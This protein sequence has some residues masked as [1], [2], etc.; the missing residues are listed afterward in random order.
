A[1]DCVLFANFKTTTAKAKGATK[2]KAWG[3]G[4][5]VMFTERRPAFDA[6]NRFDLP[7]E[8]SLSWEEF[9]DHVAKAVPAAKADELL[10]LFKG[11]EADATA[12]L[13]SIG[14]LLDGQ[15]L[16]DLKAKHRKTI[17]NRSDDFL[18]AVA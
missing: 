16:A 18:Q 4:T 6:K 11:R 15:A 7:F 12:Y 3:D 8:M 14:W 1:A 13:V 2:A 10:A 9:S 5:R 17:F